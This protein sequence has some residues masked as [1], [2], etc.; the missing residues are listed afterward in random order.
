M[1]GYAVGS[2]SAAGPPDDVVEPVP[3][4]RLPKFAMFEASGGDLACR[5]LVRA[6]F[7]EPSRC[8]ACESVTLVRAP[9]G[10]ALNSSV[11]SGVRL[12]RI[13]TAGTTQLLDQRDAPI[14]APVT[15]RADGADQQALEDDG[16]AAFAAMYLSFVGTSRHPT[17][18]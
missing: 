11:L 10:P 17:L 3:G 5:V 15:A 9:E 16:L 1:T 8:Y 7:D 4:L 18:R 12:R 14:V 2:A 13:V 6:V